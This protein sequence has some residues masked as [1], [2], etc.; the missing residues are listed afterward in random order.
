MTLRRRLGRVPRAAEGAASRPA[1]HV[2][3]VTSVA[4][5][6]RPPGLYGSTL[7]VAG[8]AVP[9]PLPPPFDCGQIKVVVLAT[10]DP[11]AI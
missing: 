4:A 2:L 11:W 1:P 3:V 10:R 8:G 6:G 5:C 9:D 7:V